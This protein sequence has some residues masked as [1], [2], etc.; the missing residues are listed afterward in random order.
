MLKAL[1]SLAGHGF[2]WHDLA[3]LGIARQA[4]QGTA[5]RGTAWQ[6]RQGRP[7]MAGLG[8]ARHGGAGHGMARHGGARQARHKPQPE[9]GVKMAGI[10]S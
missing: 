5:W 2:A 7:G 4:G 9:S 1:P 10:K 8:M 3:G 6:A